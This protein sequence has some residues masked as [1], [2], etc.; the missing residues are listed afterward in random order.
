VIRVGI[1][2]SGIA[3]SARARVVARRLFEAPDPRHDTAAAAA[4]ADA[5]GH[6]TQV[7]AIVA[8]AAPRCGL[9]DARIFVARLRAGAAEVAAGIDWLCG[10]RVRLINMSFGLREDLPVL[11][12]ACARALAQGVVLVASSPARGAPVFPA[13]YPGV[14]R[15]TGDARCA[16]GE[17]SW[18]GTAQADYGANVRA[19]DGITA[20]AS[21]GC[22]YLSAAIAALLCEHPGWDARALHAE[23]RRRAAWRGAE[24]R[25]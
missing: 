14:I 7:A 3:H 11:R 19:P 10:E 5:L 4:Q 25:R 17:V 15:A 1:L 22:A 21:I 23:L 6:G 18:L 9:L 12:D 13:R 8:H 24:R 20:G 16:P 2:D